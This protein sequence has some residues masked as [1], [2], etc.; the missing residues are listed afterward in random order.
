MTIAL[1]L[2]LNVYAGSITNKKR[3]VTLNQFIGVREAILTSAI[4]QQLLRLGLIRQALVGEMAAPVLLLLPRESGLFPCQV[5]G[6]APELLPVD[7]AV[8]QTLLHRGERDAG[9]RV[10]IE[11]KC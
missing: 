11:G 9:Y 10:N 3:T 8:P 4:E 5:G 2:A 1:L 7:P 6:L